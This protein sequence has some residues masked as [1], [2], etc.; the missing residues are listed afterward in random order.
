MIGAYSDIR[1]AVSTDAGTTWGFGFGGQGLNSLY[2][3]AAGS[4]GT[5]YAAT[6]SVHDIYQS[7]TLTDQRIDGGTG[8]VLYSNDK[9]H[10]WL[11]L[12]DFPGPVVWV[13]T[14]PT[15]PNRL[16]AAVANSFSG[17]IYVSNDINTGNLS[18]WT[19]AN[20]PPRTEG[21]P[22]NV[23]VLNDGTLVCTYSGRRT[24]NGDFT[25]SSGVFISADGGTTWTDRSSNKMLYWTKDLVVD[26][27][28]PSQNTWYVG[29]FSGWGGPPNGLGGLYKTTN[30]GLTWGRI[31]DVDRVTSCTINP[32]DHNEMYV[33]TEVSGLWYSGNATAE[34][35]D[36]TNVA[37]YTFRQPERV[38]FNPYKPGEVWV[39]SFGNGMKVGTFFSPTMPPQAPSLVLPRKDSVGVPVNS[40]LFWSMVPGATTYQVQLSKQS[41]FSTR[42]IDSSGLTVPRLEF[43]GLTPS[44]KYYWRVRG[45]NA[46]GSGIW[47]AV[48]NF[49]T[50]APGAPSTAPLL[51]SPQNDTV[52]VPLARSLYWNSI[53]GVTTYQVQLSTDPAFTTTMIDTSGLTTTTL[54]VTGLAE[55]THYYWRARGANA[56]GSGPW[57]LTWN[58]T[59][60]TLPKAPVAVVLR[61]PNDGSTNAS[62]RPVLQWHA[63]P[64][65]TT[66]HLQLS[67]RQDFSVVQVDETTLTDTVYTAPT[68][69]SGTTYYWRVSAVNEVGAGPWSPTWSFTTFVGSSVPADPSTGVA[70]LV[71]AYPNPVSGKAT[72][73]LD[74]P[75]AG[76]A[77]VTVVDGLGRQMAVIASEPMPRG[78][79]VMQWDATG[80][81]SGEYF[82]RL[83]FAGKVYVERMTVV[84]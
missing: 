38:F 61:S 75:G 48:W 50:A 32:L 56:A 11:K 30:R 2:R 76:F 80:L 36:F 83:S 6:S 26:P 29:V 82:C 81:P 15:N 12:H 3:V 41:D 4:N 65:A 23:V 72:I 53:A 13:A 67:M 54:P 66:Y 34:T 45:A 20:N 28:D 70:R 49:T 24:T 60:L 18:T 17:G 27:H 59:S 7:T 5:L 52:G 55:N 37:S 79:R 31:L 64:G 25:N 42:V 22:F 51:V 71:R 19:K 58:F 9:G 63:V 35:P 16:Y 21:H 77:V 62:S 46:A 78:R 74:L 40:S 44:T 33:T 73:E 57:S 47:S 68:L 14:D 1:G 10:A 84:R 69:A 39:S 8:S 43:A